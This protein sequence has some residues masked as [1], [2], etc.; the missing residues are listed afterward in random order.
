MPPTCLTYKS[1]LQN[2]YKIFFCFIEKDQSG[3]TK[4]QSEA[5]IEKIAA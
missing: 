4:Q 2:V 5:K 3:Q 1:P